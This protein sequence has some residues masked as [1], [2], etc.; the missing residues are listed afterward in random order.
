MAQVY[1]LCVYRDRIKEKYRAGFSVQVAPPL[2]LVQHFAEGV[3]TDRYQ[4]LSEYLLRQLL[5]ELQ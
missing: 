5:D 3:T 4:V 2:F 1:D